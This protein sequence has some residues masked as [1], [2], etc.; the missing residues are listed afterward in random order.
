MTAALANNAQDNIPRSEV[1]VL[2]RS[3][4]FRPVTKILQCIEGI[5]SR[6]VFEL[7]R[8]SERPGHCKYLSERTVV[9]RGDARKLKE[10]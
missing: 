2:T 1:L 8:H 9:R 10:A 6:K 3:V 5:L 4:Q 7:I